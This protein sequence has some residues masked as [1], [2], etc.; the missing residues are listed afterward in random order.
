MPK[1]YIERVASKHKVE[2]KLEEVLERPQR[3]TIV[4]ASNA[5]R[6]A[7][8]NDDIK[9]AKGNTYGGSQALSYIGGAKGHQAPKRVPLKKDSK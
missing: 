5:A 9:P 1:T 7:R 4:L 2:P 6:P 3:K 8:G